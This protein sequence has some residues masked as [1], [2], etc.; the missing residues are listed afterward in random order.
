MAANLR[1]TFDDICNGYCLGMIS[2]KPVYIKHIGHSDQ[3]DLETVEQGYF[4]YAKKRGL[5]TEEMRL[6]QLKREGLWDDAKEKQ[7]FNAKLSID[8]MIA[9]KKNANLPSILKKIDQQIEEEKAKYNI[10]LQEKNELVSL[11]C[12]SYSQRK[13]NEYYI[14][15]NLYLDNFFTKPCFTPKEF[16]ELDDNE[17]A[18]IMRIYSET[19]TVCSESNIKKLSIQDFFQSYYFICND[20]FSAF[21][22]RPIIRLSLLQVKLANYAK[23]FKNIFENYD[24]KNMP[25]ELWEDPDKIVDWVQATDKARKEMEK[26]KDSAMTGV[27]G[28]TKEDRKAIGIQ[29]RGPDPLMQ[30]LQAKGGGTLNREEMMKVLGK[31]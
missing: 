21:Y 5:P 31:R 25:K 2:D 29:D 17:I 27:A 16:A 9:G 7:L 10:L 24:T 8:S 26:N 23:Y 20:D 14:F 18:N 3:L 12:E 6:S 4:E 30:A 19:M 1:R 28:M 13:L 22:G 11:T 15:K